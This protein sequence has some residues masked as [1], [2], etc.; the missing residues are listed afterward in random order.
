MYSF[1]IAFLIILILLTPGER[2][3]HPGPP[4]NALTGSEAPLPRCG[5][6]CHGSPGAPSSATTGLHR[7]DPSYWYTA[8]RAVRPPHAAPQEKLASAA[9]PR[10]SAREALPASA[11][12]PRSEEHTSELQSP[13]HLVCRLLLE[14]KKNKKHDNTPETS[15][16]EKS[17]KNKT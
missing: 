7:S 6:A 11:D 1:C 16:T 9:P 17:A 14:K 5:A 4:A 13:D 2:S 12:P 15:K 8:P 3:A 10:A